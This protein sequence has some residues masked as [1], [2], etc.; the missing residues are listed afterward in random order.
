[1][2]PLR[3]YK[4]DKD[5]LLRFC[6]EPYKPFDADN[7][8]KYVPSEDYTP[9]ITY[10]KQNNF[11]AIDA[12]NHY[13]HSQGLDVVQ[14]WRQIDDAIVSIT[15]SK[16]SYIIRYTNLF[17]RKKKLEHFELLRFDF[18]IDSN[19]KV[20]LME[21]NMNATPGFKSSEHHNVMYEQVLYNTFTIL[22]LSN[23]VEL[24]SK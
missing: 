8:N 15:L 20:Y 1:M 17:H 12:F 9:N 22:G 3:I 10:F 14:L 19:L 11:S 6:S 21:I 18:I 5:I 13:L 2:E 7:V 24:R 16:L 4:Y 23:R